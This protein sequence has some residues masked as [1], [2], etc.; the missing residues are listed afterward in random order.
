LDPSGKNILI[1]YATFSHW[2][3]P[4]SNGYDLGIVGRTDDWYFPA[5]SHRVSLEAN[6][7]KLS[8]FGEVAAPWKAIDTLLASTIPMTYG[9][10]SV[11]TIELSRARLKN[12]ADE[13]V[14]KLRITF[15]AQNTLSTWFGP[16]VIFDFGLTCDGS[17]TDFELKGP[18]QGKYKGEALFP[19]KN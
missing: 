13:G 6:F 2:I 4:T 19:S 11:A 8:S 17:L 10:G 3:I 15:A 9:Q 14:K 12:L 7:S 1:Q 5:V 18:Q 16:P